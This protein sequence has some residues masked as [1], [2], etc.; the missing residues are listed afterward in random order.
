MVT[1]VLV[2]DEEVCS[3]VPGLMGGEG[4]SVGLRCAPRVG[5]KAAEPW[6]CSTSSSHFTLRLELGRSA[7]S[8]R[9]RQ[10]FV[11][12]WRLTQML[13]KRRSSPSVVLMFGAEV[14]VL[15]SQ[16]STR[17]AKLRAWSIK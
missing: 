12:S 8:A 15:S 16:R 2:E 6:S 5:S 13:W 11:R 1:G 3:S 17:A 4:L 10:S 14:T 7:R 9:F